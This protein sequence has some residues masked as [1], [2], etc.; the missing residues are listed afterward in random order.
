MIRGKPTYTTV[1]LKKI[2][3]ALLHMNIVLIVFGFQTT[4]TDINLI[5]VL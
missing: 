5:F 2:I 4:C 1:T 3:I